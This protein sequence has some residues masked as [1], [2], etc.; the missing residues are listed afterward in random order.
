MKITLRKPLSF[1]EIGKKCNQEDYLWPVAEAVTQNNKVFLLCDGVGGQDYG[2]V[3]SQIVATSIGDFLTDFSIK[4]EI[5]TKS[6][7]EKALAYG[8]DELDKIDNYSIRKMA[9]TM[10]CLVFH[11]GGALVAHIGDSR[12]YHI[13]PSLANRKDGFGILYQST[14]H[15]LINELL[16]VGE[17]TARE[18][19][20][21]PQKNIITRAM[22]PHLNRRYKAEIYNIE[23]IQAGDFFFLCSDGVLEQLTNEKLSALIADK[24]LDDKGKIRAIKDLCYGKTHD[25]YTC[26]LIPIDK[27][28][29]A[30]NG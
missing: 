5:I 11:Q 22:Q 7:F 9:T 19:M 8:Y 29:G 20:N 3:A 23:E 13:R 30:E 15:S 10:T 24:T 1:S 6:I 18:A 16:R 2:E 4:D 14:D 17:I 12:I 27:V 26:W 21:F 25:N 28:D